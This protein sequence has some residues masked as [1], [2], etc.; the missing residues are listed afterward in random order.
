[1]SEIEQITE[2]HV[3]ATNEIVPKGEVNNEPVPLEKEVKPKKPRTE[4]QIEAFKKI[5]QKRLENI[6]NKKSQ[7]AEPKVES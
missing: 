5:Q 4:K 7:M 1:M 6:A 3:E 2:A